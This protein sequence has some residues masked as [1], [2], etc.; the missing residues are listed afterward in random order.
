VL[1][2]LGV[3]QAILAAR[4]I[5]RMA[6]TSRGRTIESCDQPVPGRISILV[7]VLNEATRIA[8]CLANLIAQPEEVAEIL[9]VDGGSVDQTR[10]IV[11]DYRLRDTRVKWIDASPVD[12][13]WTGKAWGLHFGL[14]RSD[15]SSQ[16]V[17]CIDAD[18]RIGPKLARSL[19]GHA[20]GTGISTFS[21]ATRQHLSG[22]AEAVIHPS[23]LTTLVYRFGLPG[24]VSRNPHQVQANGQCFFSRREILLRTGAFAAAQASLCE[25]ITIARRLAESGEP[26][27]F[28][29]SDNLADAWMYHDWRE[30]WTNWPRSLP[31]RDQYFASPEII[32][33]LEIVFVQSLPLPMLVLGWWVSAPVWFALSNA[34]LVLIRIGVLAGTARAY[35]RRPWTYW[36][37]PLCDI[38]V[39]VRLIQSALARQHSW[40]GRSYI[41]RSSGRFEPRNIPSHKRTDS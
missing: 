14:A 17:L 25:D 28:Y 7:P 34:L 27:G 35:H 37:S 41:Q 19:L 9:V 13:R 33:L 15:P 1:F 40:R 30:A 6:K 23:F 8:Q 5:V 4:V 3:L 21:L 20:T 22:A 29:E 11:D 32:G 18:V 24:T 31:M 16:W 38:A 10:C 12:S 2:L 26:V 36:L 39:A